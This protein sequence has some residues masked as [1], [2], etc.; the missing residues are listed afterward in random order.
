M[1]RLLLAMFVLGV[2]DASE[3]Q[4]QERSFSMPGSNFSKPFF[5][6]PQMAPYNAPNFFDQTQS[7]PKYGSGGGNFIACAARL[8]TEKE[9]NALLR[10][11]IAELEAELQTKVAKAGAAK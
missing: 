9:L 4:Q 5:A 2:A 11:R 6:N 3:A 1:R 7:I 8:Q 10:Q